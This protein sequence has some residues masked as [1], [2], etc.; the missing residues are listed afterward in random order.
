M[1]NDRDEKK[2]ILARMVAQRTSALATA[3][4]EVGAIRSTKGQIKGFLTKDTLYRLQQVLAYQQKSDDEFAGGRLAVILGLCDTYIRRH[5]SD[6]TSGAQEKAAAVEKIRE[7]A[8]V[9][10]AAWGRRQAEAQYLQDAYGGAEKAKMEVEIGQ[11]LPVQKGDTRLVRQSESARNA[12]I[13]QAQGLAKRKLPDKPFA[14]FNAETLELVKQFGLTEGEILAVKVYTASDYKYMNPA[15]ANSEGWM[16]AQQFEEKPQNYATTDEGIKELRSLMEEGQLHSAMAISALKKLPLKD[17]LCYRG[18]RMTEA[19]FV[20]KYG[21]L[22]KPVV[23]R[24]EKLVT[25]TSVST[26]RGIAEEFANGRDC[27]K[28]EKTVSVMIEIVVKAAR[29]ISKLSLLPWEKEHLLMPGATVATDS[30]VRLEG[31]EKG[32][33]EA[34]HWFLAKEHEE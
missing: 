25:L 10:F 32:K 23:A 6:A 29:D 3:T 1:S 5:G 20:K 7:D 30:I 34:F 14:G 4:R 24:A 8:A 12:A 13:P 9:E 21:D 31:G 18:R 28:I 16:A 15:T 33:P 11:R 19:D 17:G 2:Q 26:N 22:Q 27:K